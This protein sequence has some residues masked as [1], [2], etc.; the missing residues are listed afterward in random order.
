MYV[1]I[2]VL[3]VSIVMIVCGVILAHKYDVW[4]IETFFAWCL[5]AFGVVTLPLTINGIN[6]EVYEKKNG[7]NIYTLKL[8]YLGGSQEV[9]TYKI[10]SLYSP[11]IVHYRG[12]YTL[13]T[14]K[15]IEPGVVRF[16]VISVQN[17]KE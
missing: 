16:E 11:Q 3:A 8:Y 2:F 17:M 12:D 13:N 14:G 7:Y 9:K 1:L 6:N 10:S 4:E 15:D 5:I